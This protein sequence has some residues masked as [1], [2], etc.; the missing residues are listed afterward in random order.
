MNVY[1]KLHRNRSSFQLEGRWL[2]IHQYFIW[3]GPLVLHIAWGE[4][5]ALIKIGREWFKT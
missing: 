2:P 1:I 5:A 3:M 4:S